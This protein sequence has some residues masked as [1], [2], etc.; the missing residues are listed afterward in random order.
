[1]LRNF[2]ADSLASRPVVV[3][4]HSSPTVRYALFLTLDLDGFDVRVMRD[5]DEAMLGMADEKPE[6]VIVE[7]T[8]GGAAANCL[9]R[10]LRAHPATMRVPLILISRDTAGSPV[11]EWSV[12]GVHHVPLDGGIEPILDVLHQTVGPIRRRA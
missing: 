5:A 7:V 12:C 9:V 6:A 11:R 3:V 2:A 4:V 1:M 10:R 8:A